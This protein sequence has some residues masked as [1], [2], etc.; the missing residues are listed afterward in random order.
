MD[1]TP[2]T[3][4]LGKILSGVVIKYNKEPDSSPAVMLHLVFSDDS[5]IEVCIPYGGL[6]F[7]GLVDSDGLEYARRY[8]SDALPVYYEA[9]LDEQGR[10][11]E[12]EDRSVLY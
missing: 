5:S 4:I 6:R 9:I 3:K 11:V 10:V 7:G 12:R 2:N 8:I 1:K